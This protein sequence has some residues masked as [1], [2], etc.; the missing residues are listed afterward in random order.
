[1]GLFILYKSTCFSE[2]PLESQIRA[3]KTPKFLILVV[4]GL[5][6]WICYVITNI[7]EEPVS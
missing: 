2:M 5:H 4:I 6:H 3:I 7:L 1:M